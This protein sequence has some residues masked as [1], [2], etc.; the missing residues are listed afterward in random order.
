MKTEFENRVVNMNKTLFALLAIVICFITLPGFK[1]EAQAGK[2]AAFLGG[3]LA[4]GLIK[5]AI[6]RD[7]RRTEAAEYQAY[8]QPR[9]AQQ[10]PA[11]A[12]APSAQPSAEARIQQLDKLAAGGY[13]TPEE[14][15]AKKKAI[16]AEM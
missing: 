10:A 1:S 9:A 12:A 4:G 16:L 14:Y 8:S 7:Q 6:D 11:Q 5:G 2:G 13:I 3:A 15:K